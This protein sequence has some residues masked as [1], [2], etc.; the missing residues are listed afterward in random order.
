METNDGDIAKQWYAA[1]FNGSGASREFKVL[2][3]CEEG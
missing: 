2:A 1:E 3:I